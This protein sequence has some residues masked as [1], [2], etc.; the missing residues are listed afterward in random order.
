MTALAPRRRSSLPHYRMPH[1]MSGTTPVIGDMKSSRSTFTCFPETSLLC[2]D[3]GPTCILG[4]L[5]PT[6]PGGSLARPTTCH[7]DYRA[8]SAMAH[9]LLARSRVG[10]AIATLTR[11]TARG[12]SI[13]GYGDNRVGRRS[14]GCDLT[15]PEICLVSLARPTRVPRFGDHREKGYPPLNRG[16]PREVARVQVA[17]APRK[18]CPCFWFCHE[19]ENRIRH[20]IGCSMV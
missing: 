6:F 19:L 9:M 10:T 2:P 16:L 11:L 15:D 14:E 20:R 18:V 1:P 12:R 13:H 17:S 7:N 8:D 5:P 3:K 4:Q